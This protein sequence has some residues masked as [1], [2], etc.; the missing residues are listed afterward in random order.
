MSDAAAAERIIKSAYGALALL[1]RNLE[2]GYKLTADQQES[3]VLAALQQHD[4]HLT[5]H[6][7]NQKSIDAFKLVCWLGG[8][9][10]D[11]EKA[12]DDKCGIIIDAILRTL[13]QILVKES[14]WNLTVSL[15]DMK[16][17][18]GFL[19]QERCGNGKHGIWMNGLYLSFHCSVANWKDGQAHKVAL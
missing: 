3:M 19:M 17:L 6:H 2:P 7:I 15:S 16:L 5:V 12:N 8:S 10:L 14:N 4:A 11:M 13:R 18:K 9:L 1:M